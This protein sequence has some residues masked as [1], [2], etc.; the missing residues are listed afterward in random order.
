LDTATVLAM[1]L[2]HIEHTRRRH[3]AL[4]EAV[5]EAF[6][7][8]SETLFWAEVDGARLLLDR[9]VAEWHPEWRQALLLCPA[10]WGWFLKRWRDN[11]AHILADANVVDALGVLHRRGSVGAEVQRLYVKCHSDLL[12]AAGFQVGAARAVFLEAQLY[13]SCVV[14]ADAR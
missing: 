9:Q 4:R 14:L 7:F 11:D 13:Y 12:D 8:T 2:T 6:G 1:K 10:F 5:V 3:A